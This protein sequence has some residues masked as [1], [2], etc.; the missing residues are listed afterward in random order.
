MNYTNKKMKTKEEIKKLATKNYR[1]NGSGG[2]QYTE[3]LQEGRIIG[4]IDG[5]T[6]CQEDMDKKLIKNNEEWA[7]QC[8]E[9]SKESDK[10]YTEEDMLNA[11]KYG[12][13]FRDTTSF[14]KHKFEDSCINNTKQ[15]LEWYKNK[16]D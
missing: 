13:E 10:K 9:I 1:S 15:W 3:G 5:Y 11:S 4:F 8:A 16:Q 14:P 6:Q 2:G 12:Y 7:K